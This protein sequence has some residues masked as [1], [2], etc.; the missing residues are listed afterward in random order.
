MHHEPGHHQTKHRGYQEANHDREPILPQHAEFRDHAD[1]GRHEQQPHIGDQGVRRPAELR[2]LIRCAGRPVTA[3]TGQ[4]KRQQKHADDRAG[5]GKV[6]GSAQH[7]ADKLATNEDG[8]GR[9][10]H[11]LAW[12]T[13]IEVGGHFCD[14]GNNVWLLAGWTIGV[15]MVETRVEKLHV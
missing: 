1:P 4:R 6:Q 2:G 3:A 10:H 9:G 15:S 13:M 8:E 12:W 7:F 14:T 5:Q 11:D